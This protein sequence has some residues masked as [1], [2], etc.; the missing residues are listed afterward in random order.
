[1]AARINAY[2]TGVQ[3]R[4]RRAE[5]AR[6][7][8]KARAEEATKRVRVERDRLRLT[9]ALAASVLGL[10][11][12]GGGGAFWPFQ[13][14]QA[15]LANVEATLARIQAIRDQAAADGADPA[16]W[17]EA[18]AAADQA[19]ASIGD[20]A[21]SEPGRRLEVLRKKITEDQTQAE[22]DRKLIEELASLRTSV[23]K[24]AWDNKPSN[25]DRG[26]TTA[27]KRYGLDLEA[28]PTT[29]AVARLKSR[30][31]A[32]VREVIGSLDHWLSVRHDL[33]N[34][35][36]QEQELLDLTKIIELGQALDTDP[37]RNRLRALLKEADL[38]LQLHTLG[39]MARQ[40]KLFEFGP[41]TAL[42]LAA[43]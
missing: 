5:I 34:S 37:E 21:A 11:L 22:S 41:S 28:T 23:S 35:S 26:F 6:A 33:G 36:E 25:M 29:T 16:R 18:L 32:F 1:M 31:E 38:K 19:L 9:V 20:M 7:E 17:R 39:A 13:Q 4:L 24:I 2:Q 10:A 27:F 42:L 8:E 30:S 12:V 43:C 3:E 14:R 40:T 15:R